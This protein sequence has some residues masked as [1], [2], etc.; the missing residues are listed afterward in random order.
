M[1]PIK[2]NLSLIM[3]TNVV[4]R[5]WVTSATLHKNCEK[6][7]TY[8]WVYDKNQHYSTGNPMY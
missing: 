5:G 4:L 7:E 2:W 8:A 3:F 1:R 6:S